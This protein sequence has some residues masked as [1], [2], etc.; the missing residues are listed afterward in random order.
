[1]SS[2]TR[3]FCISTRASVLAHANV[4]RSLFND[5]CIQGS[6]I[7]SLSIFNSTTDTRSTLFVPR[8]IKPHHH[9]IAGTGRTKD[10]SAKR[11]KGAAEHWTVTGPQVLTWTRAPVKEPAAHR[12]V[13][14]ALVG[15]DRQRRDGIK[16]RSLLRTG[17]APLVIALRKERA[18]SNTGPKSL[19]IAFTPSHLIFQTLP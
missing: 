6:R 19:R 13:E 1:M 12:T 7:R 5:D 3:T 10:I 14:Q 17:F 18:F 11:G 2:I 8:I 9:N 16:L 15:S 4:Q